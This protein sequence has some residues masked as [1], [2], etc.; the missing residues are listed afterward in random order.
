MTTRPKLKAIIIWCETTMFY[1]S[2][3]VWGIYL[4]RKTHQ[5]FRA[6]IIFGLT[7]Q[8]DEITEADDR[9]MVSDV[10]YCVIL[11]RR[12]RWCKRSFC[13]GP[14]TCKRIT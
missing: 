5:A 9:L 11:F 2:L 1:N 10:K 3:L 14:F 13:Q 7:N 8:C 12:W 6:K 4:C